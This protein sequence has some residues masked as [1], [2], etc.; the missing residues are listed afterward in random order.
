MFVDV[1]NTALN[2]WYLLRITF[3]K[4][5]ISL[6][7]ISSSWIAQIGCLLRILFSVIFEISSGHVK[8]VH[9]FRIFTLKICVFHCYFF[10][11]PSR[12]KRA[13]IFYLLLCRYIAFILS[14]VTTNQRRTSLALATVYAFLRIIYLLNSVVFVCRILIQAR[15]TNLS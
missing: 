8:H 6:H 10:Y 9:Y 14:H 4:I 12:S 13:A 1:G 5:S 15:R 7:G 2:S 3:M 11:A